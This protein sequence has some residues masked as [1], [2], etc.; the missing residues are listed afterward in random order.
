[1]ATI[2]DPSTL[3][4][5]GSSAIMIR[6]RDKRRHVSSNANV[7]DLRDPFSV[8]ALAVRYDEASSDTDASLLEVPLEMGRIYNSKSFAKALQYL[9]K[10][11]APPRQISRDGTQKGT[12]SSNIALSPIVLCGLLQVQQEEV[13][14]DNDYPTSTEMVNYCQA[15]RRAASARVK[16][17]NQRRRIQKTV[18][19]ILVVVGSIVLYGLTMSNFRSLL[20]DS[21]FVDSCGG[22]GDGRYR[23][24]CR[25]AEASLWQ[26]LYP[27]Y[28]Q[29]VDCTLNECVL[30]EGIEKYPLYALHY[31][32]REEWIPMEQV[33]EGRR[34]NRNIVRVP[35]SQ[36]TALQWL[37]ETT[38]NRLVREALEEHQTTTTSGA[39]MKE[40]LLDVGCGVG[41]TLYALLPST[42]H[43]K[44]SY[45]GISISAPEIHQAQR[46]A[47]MHQLLPSDTTTTTTMDIQFTQHN[48]DDPLKDAYTSMIAIDSLS[49]SHNIQDTL[50]NLVS[51]LQRG[52]T[53]I[54][55]TDVVA[56]WAE[57]AAINLLVNVTARAS[58]LTHAEWNQQLESHGLIIQQVRDLGLEFDLHILQAQSPWVKTIREWRRRP[59][60]TILQKWQAWLG[61]GATMMK[62]KASVRI[63][64]LLLDLVQ[65]AW[66][67]SLRQEAYQRADLSYY[68]Y[69]CV[70]K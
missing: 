50:T 9:Q 62:Q 70:K 7:I 27:S 22:G 54:L 48:F 65:Q 24:A 28:P 45:H 8:I 18:T 38:V 66:G 26:L 31:S 55:V 5:D 15:M 34:R 30:Q 21:G 43:T 19:P 41:G 1:M 63:V 61:K 29:M 25:M 59:A 32:V 11:T 16:V 36:P 6:R 13:A 10:K 2:R 4:Q 60:Q 49:Y 53:M 56:P 69:T 58:L 68:M 40:H 35:P 3:S 14:E 64:Q 46:L 17:R 51:S 23:Q 52:G 42:S 20:V 33:G 39:L 37:G 44:L 67:T 47:S 57:P 12:T